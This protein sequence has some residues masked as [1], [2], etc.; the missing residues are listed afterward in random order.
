[1]ATLQTPPQQEYSTSTS[2]DDRIAIQTALKF[3]IPYARIQEVLGV[4]ENQIIYANSHRVTPQKP[5]CRHKP[6]LLCTP[7]RT[8]L[9]QWLHAS[10]SHTRIPW[11]QVPLRAPELHLQDVGQKALHTAFDLLG[12]C[13]RTS[14]KKGYSEDPE[15]MAERLA[16][17]QDGITW[18]R[19][20]LES[21]LFTDEVWAMGGAHT[22]SYVTVRKDGLDRYWPANL[23]HKY[24]RAPAWMYIGSIVGGKKAVGLFWEKEWGN[25][26]S[27]KYNQFFL[28]QI[29][30]YMQAHPGLIFMQDNA[31]SH[32]SQLTL[33]NLDRRHIQAIKWPRYSAD[34][35]LIEHVWNWMKNWI[36]E[37]YWEVRYNVSSISLDRL[38]QIISA[39]WNACP[40]SYIEALLNSWW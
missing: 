28:S 14:K 29:E 19:A 30:E 21:Q 6:P 20:R 32:R 17:A 36:Q 39:A 25:I 31:P 18:S 2:R 23:Q 8:A 26:N 1:M 11:R 22:T 15:V 24:S 10:P 37:N 34:L 5:N 38:R 9:N 7:Q 40:D 16:F 3:G 35:N 27:V 33:R 12:Y 13:R 4:T